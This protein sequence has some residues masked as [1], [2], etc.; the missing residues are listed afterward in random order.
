MNEDR[1]ATALKARAV[2]GAGGALLTS[3]MRSTRWEVEGAE[4]FEALT[5]KPCVYVLWHGRLLPCSYYHRTRGLATLISQHRDGDYIAGVVER[6]WGF[7]A[8]RGSSSRGGT[9]A[10]REIVRTLRRGTAVAIT[11]DG[12]RGPRQ[13]MKTGPLLAA[14]LAGVPLMPVSAG[15]RSAWW[16]GGWDRFLIPKPFS[17]IRLLYGEPVTVPR[18]AGEREVEA[19][20]AHLE[21]ELNQLTRRA[22]DGR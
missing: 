20:A 2:V 7:H 8:I 12:P 1:S 18:E 14:Q 10:L 15:S 13:K 11:P 21:E 3:L 5:G 19:I 17:R 6:W 4:R 9:S 22:D 16:L